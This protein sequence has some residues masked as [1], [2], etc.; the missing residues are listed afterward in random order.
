MKRAIV[1]FL[2]LALVMSLAA[3]SGRGA[4]LV[5]SD[6]VTEI[7]IATL[8]ENGGYDRT[9]RD[10]EKIRVIT[11]YVDQLETSPDLFQQGGQANGCVWVITYIYEDGR[12]C[13]LYQLGYAYFRVNDGDFVQ[14][15]R[16][17]AMGLEELL[18]NTPSD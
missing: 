5:D 3:C 4:E 13:T 11:D 6:G 8:P 2:V 18:K 7:R 9:Y 16:S 12:E 17:Q 14:L 1:C 10:P 15:E